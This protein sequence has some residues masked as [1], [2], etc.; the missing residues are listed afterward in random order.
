KKKERDAVYLVNSVFDEIK[1]EYTSIGHEIS[2]NKDIVAA[3]A[4]KDRK[5]LLNL[6]LPIYKELKKENEYL[7]VMHFHTVDTHSYLR[8]HK[9]EKFG[10]DLSL[11]RPLI[12]KTNESKKMQKGLETGKFGIY[13]RVSFP[14]F[15]EGKHIGA[16]EL[17]VDIKYL[18]SRISTLNIFKPV[19]VLR[20]KAVEPIHKY[21][22]NSNEYLSEYTKDYFIVNYESEIK[23]KIHVI[24]IMD[25][26][27]IDDSYYITTVNNEKYLVFHSVSLKNY[28]NDSIGYFVF[29][30]KMDY[31]MDTIMFLRYFSIITSFVLILIIVVLIIKLISKYTSA[32]NKQKDILAYQAH[33]DVLT[34]L[35]NR[36]LFNDRLMQSIKNAKR[37]KEEV[38]LLFIDLDRFKHINDSLGHVVGDKVLQVIAGRLNNIVRDEDTVARLGGD[39]FTI[40]LHGLKKETDASLLAQKILRSIAEVMFIDSHTLYI[41]TSIGISVYPEDSKDI[42]HLIKYA[43]VAMYKAKEEGRNNFQYYS[44][45]MTDLAFDRVVMETNL[46][47]A[48]EK[49]QFVVYYQPQV[50][51]QNNKVIGMEA[52]VRWQHPTMGLLLPDK[53]IPLAEDTGLIVQLDRWVMKQAMQQIAKWNKQGINTGVLAL[54]LA[55]RQLYEEDF[56]HMFK[57]MINKTGCKPEWLEL[58]V[59][60]GDIMKKPQNTIEI[61]NLISDMGVELAIDDF[62]T[63]YSSLSYLKRLPINKLKIDQSFIKDLPNDEED[64]SITKAIISLAKSL[65]LSVIAEGV[66]N[67]EQ[68]EFLLENGCTNIQGYFYAKPMPAQDIEQILKDEY[69]I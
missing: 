26:N 53:F 52:L 49:E 12:V 7:Y 54:N 8:V 44:S 58:E 10:D 30:D 62:G 64:A 48:L 14:V 56:I 69:I 16:F 66:E 15:K 19:L 46:R 29:I 60:E 21:N 1:N 63:G 41:S 27:I 47:I 65:K 5:K 25:K 42:N 9:P 18:M 4:N 22:N 28:K 13:Y 61:L 34:G 20:K 11:L 51:A 23:N 33:H 39:E 40:I 6:T 36:I 59:T 2:T 24:D 67:E 35:P 32:L 3:F 68:K 38:A 17:G 45:N 37:N 57:K 55:M 50:N 43:D 31:Y